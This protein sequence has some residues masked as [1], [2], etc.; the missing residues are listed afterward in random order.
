M[1]PRF[2]HNNKPEEVVLNDWL[3]SVARRIEDDRN[4]AEQMRILSGLERINFYL[5]R[6]YGFWQGD[7]FIPVST[8]SRM[9]PEE[10]RDVIHQVNYLTPFVNANQWQ[11]AGSKPMFFCRARRND[12]RGDMAAKVCDALIKFTESRE[13]GEIK[14]Q[15]FSMS[16][17]M[18]GSGVIHLAWDASQGPIVRLSDPLRGVTIEAPS[19]TPVLQIIPPEEV[20]VDYGHSSIEDALYV[21]R[22]RRIARGKILQVYPDAKATSEFFSR[23]VAQ[24]YRSVTR[25]VDFGEYWIAPA[26][27]T[28]LALAKD[29][30]TD[31]G[32]LPKGAFL[33]DLFPEGLHF[34]C[35]P[36]EILEIAPEN[37]ARCWF[38]A[39][40]KRLP[41]SLW[42]ATYVE[43]LKNCQDEIN[44]LATL[45]IATAAYHAAPLLIVDRGSFEESDF[46]GEPGTIL[47]LK[48]GALSENRNVRT[49]IDRLE[50]SGVDSQVLYVIKFLVE[51]M[52]QQ[53]AA[54][55]LGGEGGAPAETAT[56]ARIMQAN[57]NSN[58]SPT[59]DEFSACRIK[60]I[61]RY[62]EMYQQYWTVPV[63]LE[64]F[65]D[66]SVEEVEAFLDLKL[67]ASVE[68]IVDDRSRMPQT[69]FERQQDYIAFATNFL[70]NRQIFTPKELEKA[71]RV[72]GVEF[73]GLL[74][75]DDRKEARRRIELV[76]AISRTVVESNGDEKIMLA[77]QVEAESVMT[78]KLYDDHQ[79][80]AEEYKFYLRSPQGRKESEF[81]RTAL[82][83]AINAH[84]SAMTAQQVAQQQVM[85]PPTEPTAASAATPVL[86]DE[87]PPTEEIPGLTPEEADSIREI[88]GVA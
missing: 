30:E 88:G 77:A 60:T 73:S 61:Y 52:R 34:R 56:A 65:P 45:V 6:P 13:W 32:T 1:R 40:L 4:D 58:M 2:T 16:A 54:F 22:L 42:G 82:D 44:R 71:A 72:F 27:Y 46:S 15:D 84:L 55:T 53:A 10:Y 8:V 75:L 33:T 11:L 23:R 62:L 12:N 79:A 43:D 49:F 18:W 64:V 19:G 35:L 37:F 85:Q 20:K 86:P 38:F 24:D 50:G 28:G 81:V 67:D 9:S 25:Y 51:T 26:L 63:F 29:Y 78:P 70:A 3:L 17:L 36:N 87:I 76:K 21:R 48:T 57:A 5:G 66:L 14:R 74:D 7:E 31:A 41:N 80:F 39:H 69:E 47:S 68:I 83:F 59:M